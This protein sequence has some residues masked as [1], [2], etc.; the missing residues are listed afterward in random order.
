LKYLFAFVLTICLILPFISFCQKTIQAV[1]IDKPPVIDGYV[2]EEVWKSAFSVTEFYQR[3]PHNGLPVSQKTEFLVC[4]DADHLYFGIRCWDDPKKIT[5]KEMA[6]D[7]S[8]GNDDRIQIIIDTYLNKRSG[9]WFQIGPR[10]SIGDAIVSENGGTLNKDWDG[11]W[12][13]KAHIQDWGWEAELIIPFKTMGFDKNLRQWGIKF[14]R[15]MVSRMEQAYWPS[16]NINNLKFQISDA[17]ILDG[18]ENINQGIGLDV[19][20]Y[21][22]TGFDTKRGEKTDRKL[23]GGVD[24]FYQI[25]PSLKSSLTIHTDFAET[26]VDD[27]Q[28]NLTRFNLF[29]PEKRDF[30]LDGANYFQ[31]GIEG[32]QESPVAKRIIPFFS[33]RIG[34]DSGNNPIPVNYGGKLTGQAGDWNIGMMY[35]NDEHE[36]GHHFSIARV[37][38]NIGK[39]SSV[40]VIGTSG[41]ALQASANYLGGFDMKLSTSTYRG[42]KNASLF[43]FGLKSVTEKMSGKDA[44]WG[45]QA[46]YP[47]DLVYARLGYHEIGKNFIAGTGFI[48]RTNIRESYGQFR[49]GPRP[50]K[51]G[52]MQFQAGVDADFI[53][54]LETHALENR[55]IRLKPLGFR[56]MSGEEVSYSFISQFERLPYDFKIYQ[57]VIIPKGSYAWWR[58]SIQYKTKGARK[59]WSEGSYSFGHFYKGNRQEFITKLNWKVAVPFFLGGGLNLNKVQ[60]PQGQFKTSIYQLNANFLFSPRIT[61]YNYLQYDNA[62][63]SIGCQ[64]RFQWILQPGREIM[65]VWTPVFLK[66]DGDWLLNESA[67]RLKVKYNI[68]F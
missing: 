62:S 33:R 8:L 1:R 52:I 24:V 58:S 40:G 46:L 53:H 4:Y 7:V 41:N 37:T 49:I 66:P 63:K 5:A 14:I 60:L 55:D 12:D 47:N 65:V 16:A 26:E 23:T 48:P 68:R 15:N 28:I 42:N 35:I 36:T 57:S 67:V 17:G 10:G 50:Q 44:S 39:Q 11:L 25:T 6:R 20:P 27:R 45:V 56:F 31:F 34:L 22:V 21:L 61:L 29:F 54:N 64:S 30:F 59:I 2:T 38:R 9:Y 18:I 3:E 51:W 32:D 19:S 43:L 13:G